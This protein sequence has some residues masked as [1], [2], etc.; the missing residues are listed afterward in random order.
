VDAVLM[1]VAPHAAVIPGKFYHGGVLKIQLCFRKIILTINIAYTD[2]MNLTNYSVVVIPTIRADAKID[3]FNDSYKPLGDTD[4]KNWEACKYYIS[5]WFN[6]TYDFGNN[7]FKINL[8]TWTDD[9]AAYDGAP[10]G[11]QI[12]GRKFEEEKCLA[13]ANIIQRV[14]ENAD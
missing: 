6:H 14:L 13:L 11:V 2:T 1:P 4:R 3:V 5:K 7:G 12:V 8:L 9:P 10:V